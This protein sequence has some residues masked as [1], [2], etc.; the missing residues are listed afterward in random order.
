MLFVA[1]FNQADG[2]QELLH[3]RINTRAVNSDGAVA[4]HVAL[5]GGNEEAALVLINTN[6]E[7]I[8]KD[9]EGNTPLHYC[10]MYKLGNT[11]KALL[12]QMECAGIQCTDRMSDFT[13]S[14]GETPLHLSCSS[15]NAA[16]SSLLEGYG[17]SQEVRN[18]DGESPNELYKR[19]LEE[20][21]KASKQKAAAKTEKLARR[22][23][24][25]ENT[26]SSTGVANFLQQAQLGSFID[27]FYSKFKVVD[28]AFLSLDEARL[29]KLG[30]GVDNIRVF[31]DFVADYRRQKRI[32]AEEQ[33]KNATKRRKTRQIILAV[34]CGGFLFL[35]FGIIYIYLK[36]AEKSGSAGPN[37]LAAAD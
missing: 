31:N 10:A 17:F 2:I 13:N 4:L 18:K 26:K 28:E 3:R 33:E 6:S 7:L 35:I 19:F 11:C 5:A 36:Y 29:R 23:Q 8:T 34:G 12:E 20:S 16:I 27:N 14:L 25:V 24:L 32:D 21:Q 1:G 22:R 30:L 9:R 15:G 37:E